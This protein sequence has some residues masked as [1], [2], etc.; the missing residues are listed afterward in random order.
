M[1]K[2]IWKDVKGYQG[3]YEISNL[4][5][6]KSLAKDIMYSNGKLYKYDE[7]I[8]VPIKIQNTNSG[9]AD[10]FYLAVNLTKHK[11]AKTFRIHRLVALHH[12]ENPLNLLEVNHKDHDRLNNNV[13]NLEWTNTREN[14]CHY[15]KSQ[16][17]SSEYVGVSWH[18]GSKNWRAYIWLNGSL[19]ALGCY[20]SE[21]EAAL[22]YQNALTENH[23][24]NRYSNF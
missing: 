5:R 23:L 11:K 2:E 24:Q 6:V 20:S 19:K 15:H 8:L 17:Y 13:I 21:V 3:L 18:K 9:R 12:L 10:D 14:A 7:R 22:A 1:E 4:G 16:K